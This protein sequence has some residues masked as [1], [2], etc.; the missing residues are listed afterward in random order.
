MDTT[1]C[2]AMFASAS[3]GQED[4]RILSPGAGGLKVLFDANEV[5]VSLEMI[6]QTFQKHGWPE[7]KSFS[8]TEFSNLLSELNAATMGPNADRTESGGGGAREL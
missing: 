6:K 1:L 7:D 4:A 5:S 2:D 3:D 8:K